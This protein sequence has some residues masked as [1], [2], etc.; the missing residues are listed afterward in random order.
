M[1]DF[2]LC[3]EVVQG[4]VNQMLRHIRNWISRKPLWD[5][6]LVPKDHQ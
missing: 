5:R 6:G 2:D 3:S 1:N 4:H